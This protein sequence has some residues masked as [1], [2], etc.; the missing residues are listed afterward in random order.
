MKKRGITLLA[1]IITIII[2]LILISTAVISY[3]G[4]IDSTKK[5][6]LAME[7]YTLRQQIL[8]YEFM[9][10]TYPLRQE[11]NLDLNNIP[12]DSQNQFFDEPGYDSKSIL[13]NTIDLYK[14]GV[15][16][17]SRGMKAMGENDIY[18]FSTATKKIYYIMGVEIGDT[19]YYTLTDELYNLIDIKNVE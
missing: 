3:D 1:L 5:R 13:L 6:D 10:G 16:S 12:I 7:V 17:L 8:D 19:I 11:I 2:A 9:N 4:I 14:A 15:N 18:V